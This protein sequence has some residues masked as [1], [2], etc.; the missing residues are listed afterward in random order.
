MRSIFL[1]LILIFVFSSESPCN[2]SPVENVIADLRQTLIEKGIKFFTAENSDEK[3]SISSKELIVDLKNPTFTNGILTTRD[4]GVVK[5]ADMR[6]QARCIQYIKRTENGKNIHKIE[7]DGDLMMVYK[8]RVFIGEELEYDFTEKKGSIY[9]GKTY[10]AP[11]YLSG[12]KIDL[13]SDGSYKIENV[14]LTTCENSDS[15]WD[16][17]ASN[18][19]VEKKELLSAKKVRFRLFKFPTLWLPSFKV[20]LKK[21]FTKPIIKYKVNWDKASGP[22]ASIRYQAYSWRDYS[23]FLRLDYRMKMG[24]GGAIETDYKPEHKRSVFVTRSYIAED[25]IPNDLKKRR[26]YRLQGSYH[27]ESQDG[28]TTA[29]LTWDKYSDIRMPN[30]FKND[31]FEI[32]TAKKTELLWRHQ[33]EDLIAIAHARAR[34]NDFE[35]IKQDIPTFYVT[36]RPL[37]SDKTGLIFTNCAR[38][39]YLDYSYADNIHCLQNIKSFRGEINDYFYRPIP[40]KGITLTPKAGF[41]GIGYSNSPKNDAKFLAIFSYG[42][43]AEMDL[44]RFFT[45]HKHIIRPY[46]EYVGLSNPNVWVDNHYVFSIADGYNRLNLLK[47]GL[48]NDL[49]STRRLKAKPTFETDLYANLFLGRSK[50][51]LL[52]PK[53]Y[54]NLIWNLPSFCFSAYNAWNFNQQTL[55]Y[56]NLRLGWTINENMAFTLEFRYR[57]QYDWRKSDHENFILD[58]TRCEDQLLQSPLSDKRCTVLSHLFLRLTPYWTFHIESHHGWN[59]AREKGYN[60]FKIDLFSMISSSWKVKVSYMHTETDDRF[61]FDYFLLKI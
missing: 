45:K 10:A 29:F 9:N 16:I 50:I 57:S 17:H 48:L 59:R 18:V 44:Y 38:I 11:W 40:F 61:S 54:L 30:D 47:I 34:V 36:M 49:F 31:D 12:D 20:N 32:D 15:S 3:Q 6:I 46:V 39:S 23:L 7:A 24:F 22:R 5:N 35:T 1:L 19:E 51:E 37:K 14:V 33:R 43:K 52:A 41:T 27:G 58:V 42:G 60:E 26:R 13:K 21:F 28:K 2:A 55:D 25:M 8:G 53:L 56:S 4:G